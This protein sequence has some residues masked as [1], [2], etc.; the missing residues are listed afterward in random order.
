[1]ILLSAPT[2]RATTPAAIQQLVPIATRVTTDL[3]V[4]LSL[5]VMEEE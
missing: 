2:A 5:V 4:E 3:I 1:M